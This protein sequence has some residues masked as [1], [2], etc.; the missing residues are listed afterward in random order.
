MRHD[1]ER[2]AHGGGVLS[3]DELARVTASN[4][5]SEF[6]ADVVMTADLL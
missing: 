3:A 6:A 5:Q 4:L 2:T 1:L